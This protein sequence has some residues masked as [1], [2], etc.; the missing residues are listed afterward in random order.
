MFNHLKETS[1]RIENAITEKQYIKNILFYNK[2]KLNIEYCKSYLHF[3]MKNTAHSIQ[4]IS[5]NN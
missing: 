1:M 2:V 3:H 4:N 5:S